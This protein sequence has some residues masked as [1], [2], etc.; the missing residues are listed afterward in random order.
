MIPLNKMKTANSN[1]S[2]QEL[3]QYAEKSNVAYLDF[4]EH[5]WIFKKI[6]RTDQPGTMVRTTG[7]NVILI[8][9]SIITAMI[10]GVW[11]SP[12]LSPSLTQNIGFWV[13]NIFVLIFTPFAIQIATGL[14]KLFLNLFREGYVNVNRNTYNKFITSVQKK[15]SN[16]YIVWFIYLSGLVC[17]F[18]QIKSSI[19]FAPNAW[20]TPGGGHLSVTVFV[21]LPINIF[22]QIL[23]IQFTVRAVLI[24]YVM[25]KFFLNPNIGLNLN[26]KGAGR[27]NGLELIGKYSVLLIVVAFLGSIL[28]AISFYNYLYVFK[29]P[30][31]FYDNVILILEFSIYSLFSLFSPIL[32]IL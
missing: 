13:I 14:T 22:H 19:S 1:Y 3:L 9:A 32:L 24:A 20:M 6:F 4:I 27:G 31:Y 8:A 2:Y 25:A 12:D 17:T 30:I 18:F 29:V 28:I 11:I 5:D 16:K 7:I 15:I 21:W 10:E 26:A 23:I